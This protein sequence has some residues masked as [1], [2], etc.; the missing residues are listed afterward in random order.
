[1]PT[2]APRRFSLSFLVRLTWTSAAAAATAGGS[3]D[4]FGAA[5]AASG[6]N[7]STLAPSG[8]G[9]EPR[10]HMLLQDS[11]RLDGFE[12]CSAAAPWSQQVDGVAIVCAGMVHGSLDLDVHSEVRVS[13]TLWES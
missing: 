3:S 9:A 4:S 10:A 5:P 12:H 7:G 11:R 8:T 1:M 13:F 6:G 2:S